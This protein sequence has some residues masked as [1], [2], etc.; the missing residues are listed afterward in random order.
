MSKATVPQRRSLEDSYKK[1]C[2]ASANLVL[3][4]IFPESESTVQEVDFTTDKGE[5]I[6]GS[7]LLQDCVFMPGLDVGAASLTWSVAWRNH[8]DS[9]PLPDPYPPGVYFLRPSYELNAR[10]LVRPRGSSLE[11]LGDLP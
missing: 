6:K 8:D 4:G 5:R 2:A 10:G 11:R 3:V 9:R 7:R 1:L